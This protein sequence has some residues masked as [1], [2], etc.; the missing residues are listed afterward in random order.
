MKSLIKALFIGLAG[1]SLLATS[2][3]GA[4]VGRSHSEDNLGIIPIGAAPRDTSIFVSSDCSREPTFADCSAQ[5]ADGLQYVF[6]DGALSR[7]SAAVPE[8]SRMLQLPA[9]MK[10]GESI[11]DAAEKL[12]SAMDIELDRS[13]VQGGQ[14]IYSSDFMLRSSAGILYSIEIASDEN[15]RLIEV[16]E[17]TDF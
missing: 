13:V 4:R 10:F 1:W 16:V 7:V 14:I 9:G 15:G 11:T 8:V 6:F 17:R 12:R 2:C 3:A 5:D